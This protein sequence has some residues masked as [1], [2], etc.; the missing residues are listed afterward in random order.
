MGD[1][2]HPQ[3]PGATRSSAPRCWHNGTGRPPPLGTACWGTGLWPC[4]PHLGCLEAPSHTGATR[5][6]QGRGTLKV[7]RRTVSVFSLG[8]TGRP[9]RPQDCPERSAVGAP[10]LPRSSSDSLRATRADSAVRLLSTPWRCEVGIPPPALGGETRV[11]EG[12]PSPRAPGV[13]EVCRT[14]RALGFDRPRAR[15]GVGGAREGFAHLRKSSMWTT[16]G[17]IFSTTS[18]MKLNLYLGLVSW[19]R[20][21]LAGT[22]RRINEAQTPPAVPRTTP[23]GGSSSEEPPPRLRAPQGCPTLSPVTPRYLGGG[24]LVPR[25]VTVESPHWTRYH[26]VGREAQRCQDTYPDVTLEPDPSQQPGPSPFLSPRAVPWR[27]ATVPSPA[28]SGPSS[29]PC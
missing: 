21:A 5:L 24:S 1:S 28:G 10:E 9:G 6:R 12:P 29:S 11:R 22:T 2:A 13:G 3:G 8:S 18:A 15:T 4:M 14:P 26:R 16:A 17:A 7:R 23:P 20:P 25:M 19:W 27:E